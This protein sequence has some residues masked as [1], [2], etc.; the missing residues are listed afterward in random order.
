[1]QIY[2][3]FQKRSGPGVSDGHIQ[4]PHVSLKLIY[5]K[6]VW[7]CPVIEA[8]RLLKSKIVLVKTNV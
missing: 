2:N 1:M 6:H 5:K 7:L 8:H 3:G 4:F